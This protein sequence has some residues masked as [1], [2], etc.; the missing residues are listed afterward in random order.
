MLRNSIGR[1]ITIW[2]AI[3]KRSYVSMY[4]TNIK[5]EAKRLGAIT[6]AISKLEE[7]ERNGAKY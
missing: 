3:Q 4:V 2:R 1:E 5:N 7:R 6:L